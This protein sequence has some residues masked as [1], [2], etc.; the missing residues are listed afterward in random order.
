MVSALDLCVLLWDLM[1]VNAFK[2]HS[3]A[4]S[5]VS[6]NRIICVSR[7]LTCLV[8]QWEVR[9]DRLVT[10]AAIPRA[11]VTAGES[12]FTMLC[13]PSTKKQQWLQSLYIE[14]IL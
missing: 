6:E 10:L 2:K 13:I 8:L 14:G 5:V 7:H 3:S 11:S 4:M 12:K 1:T 9:P